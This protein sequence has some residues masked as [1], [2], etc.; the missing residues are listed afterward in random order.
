MIRVGNQIIKEIRRP[1]E[2]IIKK[3]SG[4]PIP[5]LGD[6]M[7][8]MMA[9]CSDILPYSKG[10]LL[11][12]AYTVKA[13]AGDNLMLYY[14][15]KHANPGDIIVVSNEGCTERALCGEIMATLAA[16]LQ[17]GGFLI[18]G[19]IRDKAE[20]AEMDFPVFAKASNPNGPYKNG[21]GEI[22]VPVAVG[23]QVIFPGDVIVGG[24]DGIVVI[25]QRDIEAVYEEAKSIIKKEKKMMEE[26][27]S[28]GDLQV[29]WVTEKVMAIGT[30]VER[31]EK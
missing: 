31:E 6:A 22:N 18:D 15:I 10:S 13:P 5:N 12:P 2:K 1:E 7:N 14:A 17:L 11:G 20:L 29:N 21:P 28:T 26:I 25:P 19:A 27:E 16:K 8:R 30:W 4:I 23:G 3:L 24:K 9:L